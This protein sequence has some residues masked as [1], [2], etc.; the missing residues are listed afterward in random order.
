[1][2]RFGLVVLAGL[3]T[4]SPLL[5]GS[6]ADSLFQEL[7]KDFGSV[8]R[9]PALQHSFTIKNNRNEVVRISSIRVSC[10]C[11]SATATRSTLNPGEETTLVA[12]MDTTRFVG[13]KSVTIYVHFDLPRSDEV[14]LVV[15]ANGRDDVQLSP[16]SLAFGSIKRGSTPTASVTVTFYGDPHIA[17]SAVDVESNYLSPKLTEVRRQGTEAVYKLEVTLRADTPVGKW[18]S[19]VWLRTS[20]ANLPRIRVPLTVE[21]ESAL[22]ASPEVV[23]LGEVKVGAEVERKVVVRG[24]K[25]FRITAIQGQD[26]A[27]TARASSA[28]ARPVHVLTVKLKPTQPGQV[29][30][31]LQVKTDMPEEGQVTIHTTATVVK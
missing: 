23:N 10:G 31:S 7:S 20:N 25:P 17:V 9:G 2:Y 16:S 19:D 15:R 8:P 30:R 28:E 3:W 4:T 6:W 27:L 26:D 1:M 13:H 5:A 11:L 18:F 12:I 21:V 22:T 29:Q 14:R 24:V